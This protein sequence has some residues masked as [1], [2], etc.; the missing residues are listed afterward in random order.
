M[1]NTNL[2]IDGKSL[3]VQIL[4]NKDLV[5]M[6]LSEEEFCNLALKDS[7]NGLSL[8]SLANE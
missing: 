3:P 5:L 1:L 6:G 2:E 4:E 8:E 7:N